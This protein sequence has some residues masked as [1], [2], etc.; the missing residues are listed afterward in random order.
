MLLLLL[1]FLLPPSL[2]PSLS[3]SLLPS[4]SPSLS[5]SLPSST[6]PFFSWTCTEHMLCG[7]HC[8]G[9]GNAAPTLMPWMGCVCR[10]H[11][12]V[13]RKQRGPWSVCTCTHSSLHTT[14]P[15]R[16][17]LMSG[18][19]E[20]R[21]PCSSAMPAGHPHCCCCYRRLFAHRPRRPWL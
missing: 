14:V 20:T 17:G 15:G 2:L 16:L 21:G 12:C 8:A 9:F 10:T 7:R 11:V 5:P 3:P 1:Q 19:G 6:P 18:L 13:L 4:H